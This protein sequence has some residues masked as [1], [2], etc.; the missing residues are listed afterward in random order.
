[1][2]RNVIF[3]LIYFFIGINALSWAERFQEELFLKPLANGDLLA[4]FN[5]VTLSPLT[6]SRQHFEL[7]PR[8]VGELIDEHELEELDVALSRG[9]WRSQ[10]W[11]LPPRSTAVGAKVSAI[12][13]Q[14]VQDIDKSWTRLT[15]ALAGQ[16]CASFN[17]LD[18]TQSINPK[19]SFA[20]NGIIHDSTFNS[21]QVK[22]SLCQ[23]KPLFCQVKSRKR[24][25]SSQGHLNE[26]L[27]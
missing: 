7:M 22:S 17:F 4:S 15:N 11:G 9:V 12:F 6:K 25:E 23:V 3:G 2:T 5:F 18:S 19:W 14:A 27:V 26:A 10:H 13:A 8:L 1:M 20:P 21:S 16:F 24:I